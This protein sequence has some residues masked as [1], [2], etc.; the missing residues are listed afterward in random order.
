MDLYNRLS[1]QQR[2]AVMHGEGPMLVTAG[3]GSG[4]THV[5]TSRILY[6]T[7]NRQ[8][9]PDR[10]LVIT[11]TR[12]A[13]RSMQTRYMEA[14]EKHRVPADSPMHART[15]QVSF[16]T[17]HSFFY[18]ILRSS[19]KYTHFQIIGETDRHRLLYPLLREIKSRLGEISRYFDPVSRE[20]IS[21]VL[22]AI[23][24][25]KNT[26]RVLE[27]RERLPELWREHY[28]EILQGYEWQ[29]E[30]RRQL[31]LDDLLTLTDQE[32]GRDTVLLQ[33]W[34]RRYDHM[35]VDEF[36]D[37]NP[38]QY[39]ILKKLCTSRGNL[40]VVGDDDQAIYGFRGAD[41]GSCSGSGKSMVHP[42]VYCRR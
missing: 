38:M 35:M 30:Q 29:K 6:L 8:I 7:Q 10:I 23:S 25:G 15:G 28:E 3:P 26:G 24:Y 17:F 22:S 40:F 20:E 32:L 4:K 21:R 33:Y 5:L 13:A 34:R 27:S 39:E 11:F 37:C 31:D 12:E 42:P 14:A 36:Q 16:G 2:M 1:E 41:P 9:A 18:Q 19:E